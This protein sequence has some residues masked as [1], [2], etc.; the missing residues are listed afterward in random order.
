MLRVYRT[1]RRVDAMRREKFNAGVMRSIVVLFAVRLCTVF[2]FV[3]D[4][5]LR[6]VVGLCGVVSSDMFNRSRSFSFVT[7]FLNGL[8]R[9]ASWHEV[10]IV[11][12]RIVQMQGTQVAI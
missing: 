4:V 3:V 6:S 2:D 7:Y 11:V 12:R 5:R 10:K 9:L 8:M 1:E